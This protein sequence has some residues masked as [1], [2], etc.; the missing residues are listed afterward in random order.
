MQL[1]RSVLIG[2]VYMRGG[3]GPLP[4]RDIFHPEF[5]RMFYNRDIFSGYIPATFEARKT[6]KQ[7]FSV[8]A[9]VQRE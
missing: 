2:L 8:E 7:A 4:G 9:T 1:E 6:Y 3:M 5:T